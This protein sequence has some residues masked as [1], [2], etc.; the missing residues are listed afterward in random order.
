MDLVCHEDFLSDVDD[1][2]SISSDGSDSGS[3][4][5]DFIVDDVGD[6]KDDRS[7]RSEDDESYVPA[8]SEDE[9]NAG[10]DEYTSK[11]RKREGDDASRS[12]V[13]PSAS[14]MED[15]DITLYSLKSEESTKKSRRRTKPQ[16]YTVD[17]F[18]DREEEAIKMHEI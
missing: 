4:L 14:D 3:D 8:E 9:D 2:E 10:G 6:E 5:N 12:L 18:S 16:R 15:D 1:V 7:D 17:T 13:G 11:G